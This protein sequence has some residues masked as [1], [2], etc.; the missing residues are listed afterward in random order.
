MSCNKF[1]K[2]K[3][4][5]PIT[6]RKIKKDSVLYKSLD[7][8]CKKKLS[9]N[10]KK[11]SK[12]INP[13]TDRKLSVS[14]KLLDF[15]IKLC[16]SQ[17]EEVKVKEK[18]KKAKEETVIHNYINP[19]MCTKYKTVKLKPHQEHVCKYVQKHPNLKGL[20]L[21]YSVGSGKTLSAITIMRC[22]LKQNEKT[23]F[24]VLTPTSLVENFKKELKKV[25]VDFG[26]NLQIYS[27]GRFINKIVKETASFC[28]N[29]VLIIDEAHNFKT[30]VK[31]KMGHN[32][33]ILMKATSIASKVILLTATPIQNRPEEFTNLYAMISKNEKKLKELYKIFAEASFDKIYK[34]LKD[35]ISYFKNTDTNDYPSVTYNDI[36][37]NM[38]PTYYKAYKQIE[39][40][41]ADN[42]DIFSESNLQIFY[43][44]IR[45]AVNYIDDKI[46][47]PKI[48][49]TI[50]HI[51][52]Q[53]NANK[54]VLIYSNWIK[55]GLSIIQ[56]RLDELNIDW[57]QVNGSMTPKQ[58]TTSVNK[59][60]NDSVMILIISSSGAEGLDLKG[61]NSV[62]ILE[63]HFNNE[64]L[65]QIVGR[66]VR[67]RSH[68]HLLPK[69]RHVE[70]YNLILKKPKGNT[71]KLISADDYLQK[72]SLDKEKE[73]N[74][75]YK[76]LIKA[77]I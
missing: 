54:K 59:F 61:T 3:N 19:L 24:F 46:V 29:A 10:C 68:E 74:E 14:S 2:N 25:N 69:F 40:N 77:S 71:D 30:L 67:Y 45:R 31:G 22:L 13:I 60:N 53:I 63:P 8:F 50:D 23:K 75:F 37:F 5:N 32:V 65:K 16:N 73:I 42:F 57:V 41:E 33:K 36:T 44:G 17:K 11:V 49:W 43:N 18:V 1:L 47:T 76:I 72:M 51:K 38:T 64:K 9:D 6:N 62:V 58:R 15:Y 55:A 39:D 35:K 34:M 7:K 48:E 56:A 70:I 52:K 66:A 4:V 12:K 20:L 27:H 26:K 21:F 28:K